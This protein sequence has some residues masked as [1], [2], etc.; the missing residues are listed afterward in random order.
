MYMNHAP[1]AFKFYRFGQTDNLH[2]GNWPCLDQIWPIFDLV[3]LTPSLSFWLFLPQ[4][5]NI[6][7]KLVDQEVSQIRPFLHSSTLMFEESSIMRKQ[8]CKYMYS[9]C[10]HM[11]ETLSSKELSVTNL[12]WHSLDIALSVCSSFIW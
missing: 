5:W 11:S 12:G 6:S 9:I 2:K 4:T 3:R 7:Q 1:T 10:G 8:A